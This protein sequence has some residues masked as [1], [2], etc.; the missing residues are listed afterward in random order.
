MTGGEKK[1]L[2]RCLQRSITIYTYLAILI[3]D[4]IKRKQENIQVRV[5]QFVGDCILIN[6]AQQ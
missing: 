1:M 4:L 5:M 3:H 6:S 2:D